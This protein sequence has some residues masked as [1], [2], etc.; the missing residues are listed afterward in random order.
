MGDF[1]VNRWRQK[2]AEINRDAAVTHTVQNVLNVQSCDAT[3]S[4]VQIEQIEQSEE[5]SRPRLATPTSFDSDISNEWSK[6]IVRLLSQP[7][8]GTESAERWARACRGVEE[9][10]RGWAAN[11]MSL[12]WSFDELFA[13]AEPFANLSLQGSAWFVGDSTITAVTAD[14][15]TLRAEGGATQRIYRKHEGER[16]RQ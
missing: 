5:S 9:F 2:L 13:F 7:L 15:I 1:T 4:S 10:A 6:A 16:L 8:P 14:A 11:A 12:G 3:L